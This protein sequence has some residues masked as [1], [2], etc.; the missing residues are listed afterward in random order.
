MAVPA[1]APSFHLSPLRRACHRY[2]RLRPDCVRASLRNHLLALAL[3]RQEGGAVSCGDRKAPAG[4]S[5]TVGGC[6]E[7]LLKD[8]PQTAVD[9]AHE[10]LVEQLTEFFKKNPPKGRKG[11]HMNPSG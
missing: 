10:R 8:V 9:A 7:D 1:Q 11:H 6:D 2:C 4:Q 3:W 5:R